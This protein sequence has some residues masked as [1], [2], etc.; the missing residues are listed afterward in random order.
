MFVHHCLV[1]ENC[2]SLFT[3]LVTDRPLHQWAGRLVENCCD[4]VK[5]RLF[6]RNSRPQPSHNFLLKHFH[7]TR[8]TCLHFS[9]QFICNGTFFHAFYQ[10]SLTK[11]D[12]QNKCLFSLPLK[13][14]LWKSGNTRADL[15]PVIMTF[16]EKIMP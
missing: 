1:V 10:K 7:S 11:S 6:V 3:C 2:S 9:K 15:P 8:N 14:L 12:V 16:V 4:E 13:F 5:T